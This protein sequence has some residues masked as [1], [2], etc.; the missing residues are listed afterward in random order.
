M[1][2]LVGNACSAVTIVLGADFSEMRS[3]YCPTQSV[4][5]FS[6]PAIISAR[7]LFSLCIGYNIDSLPLYF[8]REKPQFS[9]IE[10]T[11]KTSR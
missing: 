11:P 5:D 2:A 4:A 9:W 8:L 3:P 6:L 7:L 1:R 10:D